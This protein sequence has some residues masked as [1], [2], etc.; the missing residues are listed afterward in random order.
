VLR[1]EILPEAGPLDLPEPG[2]P[3]VEA[4][5]DL[6]GVV[7]LLGERRADRLRLHVVGLASYEFGLEAP[8]VR[9]R[10][11]PGAPR[12][13]VVDQFYRTILPLAL[14]A[15]GREVLHASAVRAPRGVVALC[16]AKTHGKSTLAFALERR[17]YPAWADDAVVFE[18]A[19]DGGIAALSVPFA[20]RLR[21]ASSA[22]FGVE[23]GAT[24]A[25]REDEPIRL[26]PAP[27]AALVV[28]RRERGATTAA[29]PEVVLR[30]LAPGEAF[31]AAL[32]NAHAFTLAEPLR[33]ARFV[34]QYLRLVARVPVHELRYGTGLDKLPAILEAL[35]EAIAGEPPA[36]P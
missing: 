22:H 29:G 4:W 1:L 13:V 11:R 27:F 8:E 36:A 10:P 24:L 19:Q 28:L 7:C 30:R 34:E 17:G 20:L 32:E 16:A 31:R 15:R 5:R 2:A 25:R 35:E 3:G 21:P 6:S 18:P 9:A 14:Q 33:K 23:G 26:E 12:R